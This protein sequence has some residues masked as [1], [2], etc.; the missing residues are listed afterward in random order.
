MRKISDKE[1]KE[2]INK[3][4]NRYKNTRIILGTGPAGYITKEY[5][6]EG[7][8]YVEEWSYYLDEVYHGGKRYSNE[9]I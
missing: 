9:P 3:V 7:D 2:W 6:K 8:R 4:N 5:Y 1:Y